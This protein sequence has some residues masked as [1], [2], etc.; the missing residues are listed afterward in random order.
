MIVVD[1]SVLSI[2][3]RRRTGARDVIDELRRLIVDDEGVSIPGIAIQEV[4]SGLRG[5]AQFRRMDAL[6]RSF[7]LLLATRDTHVRAAAIANDCQRA[8]VAVT[9]PDCLIAA[10]ALERDAALFTTDDDFARMAPACHLALH[11]W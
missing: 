3:Y 10:H 5:P 1:T 6:L 9:A 4:L 7:P 8:G 11:R 2:A